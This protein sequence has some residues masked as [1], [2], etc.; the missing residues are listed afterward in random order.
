MVKTVPSLCVIMALFWVP[1]WPT[2]LV[3]QF[4]ASPSV[5]ISKRTAYLLL[6]PASVDNQI[7]ACGRGWQSL[8]Q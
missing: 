3:S 2:W 5:A 7:F 8:W 6:T 1:K 4:C